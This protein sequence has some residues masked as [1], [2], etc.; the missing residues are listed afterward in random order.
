[1]RVSASKLAL[2][3]NNTLTTHK[4]FFNL[5]FTDL[6][7]D[8]PKLSP[9][10]EFGI[11]HGTAMQPKTIGNG[12]SVFK[13]KDNELALFSINLQTTHQFFQL[14]TYRPTTGAAETQPTD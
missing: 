2:F 4:Y 11:P 12:D 5:M 8:Q 13:V 6:L 3:S 9:Q 14:N 1:M 7:G 10:T